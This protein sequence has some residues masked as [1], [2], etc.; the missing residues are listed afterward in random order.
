[1]EEEMGQFG[2]ISA[3]SHVAEPVDL[4]TK[5]IDPK[6]GERAPRVVK[7]DGVDAFVVEGVDLLPIAPSMGAGK[8]L[9]QLEKHGSFDE[10]VRPGGYRPKE[11]LADMETDGVDAEVLYPTFALRMYRIPDLALRHESLIAYNRWLADFC[12]D[13]NRLA[14]RTALKGIGMTALDNETVEEAVGDLDRIRELGLDGA[15]IAIAPADTSNYGDK[16]FDPFWAKAQDLDMAIS[17]HILTET[18]GKN[19][20][21]FIDGVLDAEDIQKSLAVMTF[22]GTFERFPKLKIISA[23]SD[24]GW[25]P[26][27]LERMD[28]M[29]RRRSHIYVKNYGQQIPTDARPSDYVRRNVWFT[30]M[31][32]RAGVVARDQIGVDKLM[33][34]SDYP[35]TDSTWPHSREMIEQLFGDVPAADRRA[36]VQDNAKKLYDI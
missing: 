34:S 6:Y 26:Y 23:E 9:D 3:D 8:G 4:W 15:M 29:Y 21:P 19:R 14:G 1:M 7:Q 16:R 2:V 22:L 20:M 25:V 11:R 35:H 5:Y 18:K 10:N 12:K 13:T 17:L 28:Y 32:D 33:W 24:A 30:F 27:F 31:R 36:I